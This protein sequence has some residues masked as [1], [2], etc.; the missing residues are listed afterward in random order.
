MSDY[1]DIMP[2]SLT[3]EDTSRRTERLTIRLK[4]EELTLLITKATKAQRT[5][6]DFVRITVLKALTSTEEP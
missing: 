1:A 3:S 2:H 6:S 5:A 4:P